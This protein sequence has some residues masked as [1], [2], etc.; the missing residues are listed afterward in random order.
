MNIRDRILRL[1]R[2]KAKDLMPNPKNW[3]RH[4]GEQADALRGVLA[5]IGFAQAL[6]AREVDNGK[7][8]KALILIDG[9]LR[10][11]T[12]PEAKIPVLV[13]DVTEEEAD[14]LLASMDPIA[15]MADRDATALKTLVDSL[16]TES[17]ALK[18]MWARLSEQ[19]PT[20]AF[21]VPYDGALEHFTESDQFTKGKA[22]ILTFD[23]SRELASN[24]DFKTALK[25]FCEQWAVKYRVQG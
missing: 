4:S 16:T 14:K 8:K 12:T 22:V 3:R 9:H 7:G 20:Q 5:E 24:A 2:V 10:A 17:P 1:D 25:A 6:V 15:A 13:L 19:V 23:I 21:E 11:E 18:E